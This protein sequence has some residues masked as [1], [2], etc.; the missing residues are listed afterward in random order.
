[1]M[2]AAGGKSASFRGSDAAE[3]CSDLGFV[4]V[5]SPLIFFETHTPSPCAFIYGQL[6][7]SKA[8][9]ARQIVSERWCE[10]GR[11]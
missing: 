7:C 9:A 11:G 10:G 3:V 2:R 4:A 8:I 1:M 5:D 6:E